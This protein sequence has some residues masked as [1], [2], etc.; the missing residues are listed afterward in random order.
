MSITSFFRGSRL[1]VRD[2]RELDDLASNHARW[3]SL[4]TTGRIAAHP[5]FTAAPTGGTWTQG[6]FVRN[7]APTELG[8]GGSKYVILGWSCIASGTPGTWVQCRCLTGN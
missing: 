2:Q 7:A 8:A 3:L 4:L 6:D 5:R 1:D